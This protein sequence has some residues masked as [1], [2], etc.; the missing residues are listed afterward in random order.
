MYRTMRRKT[1]RIRKKTRKMQ[2]GETESEKR[3]ERLANLANAK[4][5]R[6]RKEEEDI[7]NALDMFENNLASAERKDRE[8]HKMKAEKEANEK[9]MNA[10]YSPHLKK[11]RRNWEEINNPLKVKREKFYAPSSIGSI[12]EE[13]AFKPERIMQKSKTPSLKRKTSSK[14]KTS[15]RS[16]TAPTKSRKMGEKVSALASIFER[17][18]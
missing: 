2:G 17:K 1:R 13:E 10:E 7:A 4:K 16:K 6:N 14:R 8:Y 12:V 11:Y 15:L 3:K 9:R 18:K 5:N